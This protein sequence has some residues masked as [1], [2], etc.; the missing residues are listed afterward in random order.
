MYPTSDVTVTMS[1]GVPGSYWAAGLH[2]GT[3][4]RSAI[5]T[6]IHATR[7]G[8]VV[9]TGWGGYGNAYGHH[10]IVAC[11][12]RTGQ[13]RRVL[14]AHLSRSRA[15]VGQRIRM[16]DVLGY[17]GD[18]GNTFGP[19]LHYEER[20]SPFSYWNYARPVFLGYRPISLV[21]VHLS[22]VRPG[23]K[24]RDI[25]RVQRR[26]NR[27]LGGRDLPVT[28]YFGDKTRAAYKRWQE[29][30]GYS[31]KDASGIPGKISLRKLGFRVVD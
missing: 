6:P 29:K 10:V 1:F 31:G 20:I 11:R 3:D 2:T 5:G 24:N 17:S 7:G 23:K 27:K 4:F 22:R 12:T 9:H 28:G 21:T 25:R 15:Y 30:L 26:L 16:G 14:Y 18:T 19:H 8:K 13:R